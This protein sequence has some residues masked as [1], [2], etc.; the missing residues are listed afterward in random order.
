[1]ARTMT[2]DE[3]AEAWSKL[4]NDFADLI[5]AESSLFD[6]AEIREAFETAMLECHASR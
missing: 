1:M 4:V 3:I 5:E 2:T 6:E